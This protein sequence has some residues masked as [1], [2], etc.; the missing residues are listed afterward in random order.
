MNNMKRNIFFLNRWEIIRQK[1][2]EFAKVQMEVERRRAHKR[3]WVKMA[4][5]HWVIA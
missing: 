4:Q 3:A 1:R 2:E 5:S